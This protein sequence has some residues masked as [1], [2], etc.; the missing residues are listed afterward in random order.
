MLAAAPVPAAPHCHLPPR[1]FTLQRRVDRLPVAPDSDA[2][3]GS[4]G[5][6]APVHADFGSGR[7]QGSRIGIP[8]DVV[9]RPT[10]RVRVR[11]TYAD[12]SDRVG[13]PIPRHVHIE[14]GSDHHALLLDR[15]SC[16][17][18]ELFALQHNASGWSAGSGAVWNLRHPRP[19]P[20]GWTSADAAG[21]PILPT[22]A[23]YDEV[24]RGAIRHALRIT[25]PRSRS[26]YVFPARH[27]AGD[28]GDPA[29]PRMGE[30][31]RLKSLAGLPRQAKIVAR[32]LERYG[33]IVADNGAPWFI[34]GAP[35]RRWSNDQLATLRRLRGSD[36]EVVRVPRG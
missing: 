10:A 35:D 13:Y 32:A 22:L 15:D 26:A 23:R 28:G 30:R 8:F 16:R 6:D 4:I 7:Y 2:V 9:S 17:L 3:V 19:R 20:A 24:R 25:V 33:A 12:E 31:L 36:F 34:T 18:Y 27:E 29:L 1:G 5:R 11:F 14:G 21:L